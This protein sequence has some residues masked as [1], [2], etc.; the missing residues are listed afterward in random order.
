[1]SFEG[2]QN[3][4]NAAKTGAGELAKLTEPQRNAIERD[5]LN[6]TVSLHI[7]MLDEEYKSGGVI[8]AANYLKS[9][10]DGGT[11]KSYTTDDL[12]H[13]K[14]VG[15]VGQRL[16]QIA[17]I[18][19]ATTREATSTVMLSPVFSEKA[20]VQA[21]E[22]F[23][24]LKGTPE[25]KDSMDDMDDRLR[26][27]VGEGNFFELSA[28]ISM[29]LAY[30]GEKSDV[31]NT[32]LSM[33]LRSGDPAR[34]VAANDYMGRVEANYPAAFDG[35]KSD[36]RTRADFVEY[37]M[38]NGNVT[39][40][41]PLAIS[42]INDK[43]NKVQNMGPIERADRN[44]LAAANMSVIA[45]DDGLGAYITSQAVLAGDIP[46]G[47]DIAL[48][49]QVETPYK[50]EYKKAFL[51]TTNPDYAAAQAYK[52]IRR[53]VGVVD[54]DGELQ[55]KMDAP[56]A[57]IPKRAGATDAEHRAYMNTQREDALHAY[58]TGQREDNPR[59][60]FITPDEVSFVYNGRNKTGDNVWV[61]ADPSGKTALPYKDGSMNVAFEADQ[62]TISPEKIKIA[63]STKATNSV[64]KQEIVVAN[65][66]VPLIDNGI[67][68][69]DP[70]SMGG[71]TTSTVELY[72]AS[73]LGMS[74]PDR[75]S[76]TRSYNA[77]FNLVK[78]ANAKSGFKDDE[79]I[80]WYLFNNGYL[81]DD[82]AGNWKRPPGYINED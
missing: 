25:Y 6:Q 60:K 76:A 67:I 80:H 51:Y 13:K 50:Q 20:D 21:L 29:R 48:D 14:V 68:R 70:G 36:L 71:D 63:N 72:D 34:I 82:G 39:K 75:L 56:E 64:A 22:D 46:E 28:P 37:E 9:I 30:M 31:I 12:A 24:M 15:S 57:L 16:S 53:R 17:A 27:V 81:Q 33:E 41:D 38:N 7:G 8:A 65:T 62:A 66:N 5:A 4:G 54:V 77:M 79:M 58:N 55:M 3:T 47:E 45:K 35:V 32:A 19:K 61:I 26:A 73:W 2:L 11:D 42:K 18:E 43:F 69:F 74:E 59:Y 44:Q 52:Q 78:Q 40:D 1:M 10:S 23:A 49:A